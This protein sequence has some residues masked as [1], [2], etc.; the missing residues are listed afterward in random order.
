[1]SIAARTWMAQPDAHVIW[2]K[3]PSAAES[4]TVDFTD[5]LNSGETVS[6]ATWATPSPVTS[7]ALTCTLPTTASPNAEVLV[8]AGAAGS[9]YSLTCTVV[10][11]GGTGR[12]L[13]WRCTVQVR[14]PVA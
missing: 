9:N 13:I 6:T 11:A 2:R 12:T 4:I 1:M 10:T 7:P 5:L 8:S 14:S 3:H